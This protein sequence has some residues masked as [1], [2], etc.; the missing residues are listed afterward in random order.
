MEHLEHCNLCEGCRF[1]RVLERMGEHSGRRFAV[2]RCMGCGLVFVSPRLSEAEN[3]A[4]YGVDY[5]RGEGFDKSVNYALL[6]QQADFRRR[7]SLGILR[8]ARALHPGARS[9]L[10]VGC[11]LG[12]LLIEA[13]RDFDLV[14][15]LEFSDAGAQIARQRSGL[16]VFV[17]DFAEVEFGSRTFD[18]INAT[19]VI[20]H[21][22][23]PMAFFAKV[24]QL[25]AP[26]GVFVYSTGNAQG[27]YARVLGKRWPYIVPEG[28]LFYF[29]PAVL[30]RYF[31]AVGLVPLRLGELSAD[32]RREVLRGEDEIALSQLL[33]VGASDPG[34]KG[35]IFRSVGALTRGPLRRVV[36]RAVGKCALPAARKAQP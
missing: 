1:A 29:S 15:G 30:D 19:E 11:G 5:F 16:E 18:V 20:E 23:D 3:R 10:D 2:V 34:L 32:V 35:R 25:L 22:R 26:G 14:A 8:K 33:Y 9:L 31:R 24:R 7:E 28:H 13:R 36:T 17:G 4:L 21:V 27:L 6:E 12:D